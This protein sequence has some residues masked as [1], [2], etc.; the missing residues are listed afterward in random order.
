MSDLLV[1]ASVFAGAHW[2]YDDPSGVP[3]LPL[4]VPPAF[5]GGIE[6]AAAGDGI[7]ATEWLRRLVARTLAPATPKA[8]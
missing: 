7:S 8:I 6:A 4:E 1:R 5:R 2:T 3:D